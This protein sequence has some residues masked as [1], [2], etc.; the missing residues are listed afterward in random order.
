MCALSAR[1]ARLVTRADFSR[2]YR[3]GRRYPGDILVLYVRPTEGGRRVGVTAG[4][5]LGGAVVRNRAKRRLR[6]AFWRIEPRLQGHGDV[7]L[8]A[9]TAAAAAPFEDIMCEMEALCAAGRLLCAD[10][11]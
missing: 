1:R 3:E 6:E 5:R 8:V 10:A 4:R 11:T 2:V 7:V 9:R